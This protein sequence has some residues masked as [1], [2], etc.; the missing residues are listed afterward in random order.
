MIAP[1]SVFRVRGLCMSVLGKSVA[2]LVI[3]AAAALV[4]SGAG[5]A[6]AGRDLYGA[7]AIS[8]T[9]GSYGVGE[10]F[11][12]PDQDSA[13]QA[14][15]DSCN[16]SLGCTVQVRMHNE[17]GAVLQRDF[18]SP[19]GT[20]SPTYYMGTGATTAAAEQNARAHSGPDMDMAPFMYLVKPLFVVDAICTSN[21]G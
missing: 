2:A 4:V 3:P 21:A 12:Y 18:R 16:G 11:D 5:T 15:K 7:I 10:A 14:A 1:V 9:P 20:V 8:L 13:D 6:H 19:W 17:C